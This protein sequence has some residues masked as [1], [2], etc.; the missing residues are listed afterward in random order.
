MNVGLVAFHNLRA[1]NTKIVS[2]QVSNIPIEIIDES[3]PDNI[4]SD[5]SRNLDLHRTPTEFYDVLAHYHSYEGFWE[6][7]D[8]VG[9]KQSKLG[10]YLARRFD[11][12]SRGALLDVGFGKNFSIVKAFIDEGIP[13]FAIDVRQ[14][15]EWVEHTM[16]GDMGFGIKK[17]W[18]APKQVREAGRINIFYGDVSLLGADDSELKDH[19]FGLTLFNGSW[20]SGGFNLT[21]DKRL[22]ERTLQACRDHLVEGGLIGIVSSRYAYLGAGY[23]FG[24][25]P[26]EKLDFIDLYRRLDLLG[27][28]RFYILGMSQD[29]FE[30]VVMRSYQAW[31][32]EK[33]GDL[34]SWKKI[35]GVIGKLRA[36][37]GVERLDTIA[38]IDGILVHSEGRIVL[39]PWSTYQMYCANDVTDLSITSL[40]AEMHKKSELLFPLTPQRDSV[41][42][43]LDENEEQVLAAIQTHLP[44]PLEIEDYGEFSSTDFGFRRMADLKK[45]RMARLERGKVGDGKFAQMGVV[46]GRLGFWADTAAQGTTYTPR[47]FI[48]R[49]RIFPQQTYISPTPEADVLIA[50]GIPMNENHPHL[51]VLRTNPNL[52]K[53]D[54]I[55][56]SLAAFSNTFRGTPFVLRFD[57]Y[58]PWAGYYPRHE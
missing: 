44:S 29:G 52:A 8:V 22:K 24:Q 45:I 49:S 37:C 7:D 54:F 16:W 48:E 58:R 35:A 10:H 47:V 32:P 4:L 1:Y 5:P 38:R 33:A 15:P 25:L 53:Q 34:L 3:D 39:G 6:S 20:S 56:A 42:F 11:M 55:I 50:G 46:R 23:M 43:W 28:Q 26:R 17:F 9:E 57:S 51:Q 12:R 30:S 41:N 18:V 14:H 2:E 19:R 31:N 40:L 36:A 13:A 27:A 21:I